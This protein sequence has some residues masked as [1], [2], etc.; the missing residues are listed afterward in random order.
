MAAGLLLPDTGDGVTYL[1]MYVE[2]FRAT[3]PLTGPCT[4]RV[5]RSSLT[6]RDELARLTLEFLDGDGRVVA[7]LRGLSSKLIRSG[8]RPDRTPGPTPDRVPARLRGCRRS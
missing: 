2:S 8:T 3:A 6:L 1:P 7:E 5:R 4:A